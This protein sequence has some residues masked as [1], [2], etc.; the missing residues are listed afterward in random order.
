MSSYNRLPVFI[1]PRE[2]VYKVSTKPL[3]A[4]FRTILAESSQY[5]ENGLTKRILEWRRERDSNPRSTSRCST[6]FKF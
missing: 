5:V 4:P 6:V 2:N 3:Q 1:V